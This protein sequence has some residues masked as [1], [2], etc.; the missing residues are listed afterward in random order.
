MGVR[1]E[2]K[3]N[4]NYLSCILHSG[5]FCALLP[6]SSLDGLFCFFPELVNNSST[7]ACEV[8]QH[9]II[10]THMKVEGEH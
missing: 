7:R 1:A 8:A 2:A 4:S 6:L 9:L 5:I 10:R 3:N